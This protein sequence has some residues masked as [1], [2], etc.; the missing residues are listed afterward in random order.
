MEDRRNR[1]IL[2]TGSHRSG[3]TW[4]GQMIARSPE[5]TYV[6]EPFNVN[7]RAGI[8]S[9]QF[10]HW[11]TYVCAEN[12]GLYEEYLRHCVEQRYPLALKLKAAEGLKDVARV[13][14]NYGRFALSS[15]SHQRVLIKDPIALFSAEWLANTFDMDVVVLIRHPAAF[16]GSI[17]QANWPHPFTHFLNQPLLIRDHLS[18]FA[19]DIELFANS[20]QAILDQA[21]LLWNMIY[22]TVIKLKERQSS[23]HFIRHEDLSTAPVEQFA[24]LFQNLHLEYSQSVQDEISSHS[25]AIHSQKEHEILSIRRNSYANLSNWKQRLT[26]QEVKRVRAGTEEL[27]HH[28]YDDNDW[29]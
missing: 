29:L 1:P 15:P 8:Y 13:V 22:A 10:E 27:C 3:S 28:F 4:V 6:H 16:A 25:L 18:E 26:P 17:K 5:V 7:P 12:G 9:G 11:F 2:V 14:R 21:I 24:D 20:D 23:W 19:D